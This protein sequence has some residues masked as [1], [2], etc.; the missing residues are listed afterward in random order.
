M[1]TRYEDFLIES[2]GANKDVNKSKEILNNLR[3][4]MML[5]PEMNFISI[6]YNALD[7][8]DTREMD[9]EDIL[10]KLQKYELFLKDAVK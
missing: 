4:I 10:A 6:M 7:T 1:I 9:D 5:K 8:T 3:N 2:N